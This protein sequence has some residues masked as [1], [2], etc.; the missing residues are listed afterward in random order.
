[1]ADK[2]QAQRTAEHEPKFSYPIHRTSPNEPPCEYARLRDEQPVC[3]ISLPTGHPAYLVTRYEDVKTVLSDS[4]FSREALFREGAPRAQLV[5]PDS[6][7]LISMDPPRHSALRNLTNREFSPRRAEAMR[8]R[9]QEIVDRLLDTMAGM[10]A[11]VDLNATLARPMALEVICELLGVPYEDQ[12]LFGAWCDH[13]MSLTKYS[14]EEIVRSNTEMRTYIADLAER[15]LEDPGGD[16]LSKLAHSMAEEQTITHEE[17]VSTG[18]MFLLAGHD[19]TVTV[20]GGGA[21]LLLRNPDQLALVREDPA[22]MDAAVEEIIRLVTPGDGTFIRITLEEVELSG[23]AIPPNSAV[24][25]PISSANRDARV[26]ENPDAL[27]VHRTDNKHIGFAHGTHFCAG[28]ALARAEV[29]IAMK[30]LF[31]RFPTL[32][33]AVDPEELRWRQTAA[34][35]GYEEIPVTW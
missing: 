15:K 23:T 2:A 3:P 12:H 34:L 32:R 26:F 25:A 16:L 8:P 13:F 20:T 33:L 29:Q 22:L 19:T 31:S 4:R 6:S 9:I 35:G 24:I 17:L 27:D 11:P 28:S 1:M 5:E 18:V 14:A 10:T 7:S 30:S 21:V